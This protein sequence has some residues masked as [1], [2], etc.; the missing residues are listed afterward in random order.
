MAV[1]DVNEFSP[2]W[3]SDSIEVS[4]REGPDSADKVVATVEATDKDGSREAGD[5]CRYEL[6]TDNQ[7][8]VISA[9]GQI[10]ALK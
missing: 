5:I 7:P 6:Q 3:P 8:F 1:S 2:D 9:Q 10:K 4:V